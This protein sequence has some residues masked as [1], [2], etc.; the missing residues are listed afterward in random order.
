MNYP[1]KLKPPIFLIITCIILAVSAIVIMIFSEI[2]IISEQA[3]EILFVVIFAQATIEN[4]LL[5]IKT[6]NINFFSPVS[7]YVLILFVSILRLLNL[8]TLL[9]PFVI[10]TIPFAIWTLTLRLN[11]KL[12]RYCRDVLELAALP[13]DSTEDG[14]TQRPL[15]IGKISYT[16]D[17]IHNYAKFLT[18]HLIALSYFEKDRV[19]L[20]IEINEFN[21]IKFCKPDFTKHTYV[22]FDYDGNVNVQIAKKDYKKYKEE[23]TFDQLCESLG[24][25]FKIFL[26]YY[27]NNQYDNIFEV[28]NQKTLVETKGNQI[29]Y[30]TQNELSEVRWAKKRN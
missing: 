2:G 23:L 28:L 26:V 1:K 4:L 22:S 9:I 13:V 17:E 6:K 19:V 7:L 5:L 18:K 12:W 11:K 20:I 24:N 16:K 21:Y 3:V 8:K 30:S 29:E 14:F 25:L 15:S 27:Q 10:L